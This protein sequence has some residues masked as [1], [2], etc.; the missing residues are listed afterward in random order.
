MGYARDV[1]QGR[2]A[3]TPFVV[4]GT[5]AAVIFGLVAILSVIAFLASWL[6]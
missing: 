4:V 2:S 1:T 6:A 5:V 3:E